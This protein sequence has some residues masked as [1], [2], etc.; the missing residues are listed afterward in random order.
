[1]K[2]VI[3]VFV[4]HLLCIIVFALIYSQFPQEF[5]VPDKEHYGENM[6]DF[7]LFSSTIQA[8]VGMSSLY[9]SADH[10]KLAVIAQQLLMLFTHVFTIYFFTL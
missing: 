2:L 8:G 4:F 10:T 7:F 6:V 1:M 5:N 9:P 3:R